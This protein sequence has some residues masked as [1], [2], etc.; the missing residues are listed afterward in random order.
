MAASEV[1]AD[2]GNRSA[3]QRALRIL[4]TE[5][6]VPLV[7]RLQPVKAWRGTI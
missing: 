1:I 6:I 3:Q 5:P 2:L 7:A 4:V